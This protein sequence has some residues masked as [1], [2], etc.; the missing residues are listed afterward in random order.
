MFSLLI[1]SFSNAML[2]SATFFKINLLETIQLNQREKHT[3]KLYQS[4]GVWH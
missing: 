2:I 1:N 3:R 4:W